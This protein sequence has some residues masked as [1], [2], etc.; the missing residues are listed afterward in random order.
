MLVDIKEDKITFNINAAESLINWREDKDGNLILAVF[1]E[2]VED[3][4]IF[5]TSSS[6]V[7]YRVL[8]IEDGV[9]TVTVYDVGG[10]VVE[11]PSTPTYFNKTLN[12]IPL[13]IIGSTNL[14]PD[15]DIMPLSS[16]SSVALQLY[17]KSADLSQA[18]FLT[19]N[20]TLIFTGVSEE[21]VPKV[22]GSVV[23]IALPDPEMKAAYTQTDTAGLDHVMNRMDKLFD[24]AAAYGSNLLGA[25]RTTGGVESGEALRLKQTANSATLQ[26]VVSTSSDG[27]QKCLDIVAEWSGKDKETFEFTAIKELVDLMLNAQ[28]ITALVNAWMAGALSHESLVDTLRR[29]GLFIDNRTTEEELKAIIQSMPITTD[30][31]AANDEDEDEDEDEGDNEENTGTA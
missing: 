14:T 1:E 31:D 15:P 13:I 2:E 3:D 26:S 17:M 9:Y 5:V 23:G 6:K 11:E 30:A 20:P 25:G 10:A 16:I 24:Q 29:T 12:K 21:D 4:D 19:C 8:S 28:E 18:E 22:V 7:N 27:I